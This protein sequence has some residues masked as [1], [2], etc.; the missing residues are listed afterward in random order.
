MTQFRKEPHHSFTQKDVNP[1]YDEGK[2]WGHRPILTIVWSFSFFFFKQIKFG[3]VTNYEMPIYYILNREP[4]C[5]FKNRC[6]SYPCDGST[7]SKPQTN[8][9]FLL[10]ILC[11]KN[12]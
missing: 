8:H 10:P 6:I 12:L 4:Q 11:H 9:S 3:L 1:G 5:H 7:P 2:A